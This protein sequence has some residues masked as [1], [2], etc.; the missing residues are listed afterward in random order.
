MILLAA[1]VIFD[2]QVAAKVL[3]SREAATALAR[4][5]ADVTRQI[6]FIGGQGLN[7]GGTEV[8]GRVDIAT[9]SSARAAGPVKA[10]ISE[11]QLIASDPDLLK[12]YLS[13][14]RDGLDVRY[15]LFIHMMGLSSADEAQFRQLIADR[16]AIGL[17]AAQTAAS[18]G[19]DPNDPQIKALRRPL[20]SQNTAALTQLLGADGMNSLRQYWT[21]SSAVTFVQDFGGNLPEPTLTL[22]QA[23]QLL[24]VLSAASG[25][26]ADGNVVLDTVNVQQALA[27]SASILNSEQLAVFTAMLQKTEASA[28]I[29]QLS[30]VK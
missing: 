5:Y 26:N 27:A 24:P 22:S 2:A 3:A 10:D 29:S 15:G 12:K 30:Q 8:D 13:N 25:R 28:K 23:Q 14:Y 6:R 19:L 18:E 1:A 20:Y 9:R 4:R 7:G 11:A 16:A 17:Q 21:E